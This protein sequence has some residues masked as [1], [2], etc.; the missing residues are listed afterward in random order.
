[1]SQ[2]RMMY[3][4]HVQVATLHILRA[5][6][7]HLCLCLSYGGSGGNILRLPR[8][9]ASSLLWLAVSVGQ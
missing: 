9:A 3:S 4:M 5:L 2:L 7:N 8:E 6:I 1:M